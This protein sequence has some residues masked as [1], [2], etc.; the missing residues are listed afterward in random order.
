MEHRA[1]RSGVRITDHAYFTA[2]QSLPSVPREQLRLIESF[3]V[4][5]TVSARPGGIRHVPNRSVA[6]PSPLLTQTLSRPADLKGM[7]VP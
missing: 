5:T 7:F 1:E 4:V 6:D 2:I 3:L